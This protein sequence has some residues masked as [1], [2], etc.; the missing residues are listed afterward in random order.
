M[1][2]AQ[3]WWVNLFLLVPFAAFFLWRRNGLNLSRTTLLLVAFFGAAFGFV[4]AA[5]VV[6]L[7]AA[8]GLLPGYGGTLADVARL[9]SEIY[10]KSQIHGDL[11]GSLLTVEVCREIATMVML[12]S[13]ALLS[14]K[15]W[16]ERSAVFLWAFA[17]WD[18]GYYLGLWLT[19][20]W[21]PSLLSP[22]VLF[23][24]PVPWLAQVWF[25]ILVSA[26]TMLA[27][28]LAKNPAR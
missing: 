6:Y 3:P 24:I 4:E 5:V 16:S 8:V 18:I 21:P 19:V 22:D 1:I 25:P 9:S 10:Q 7:R 20:G 15:S 26:L 17:I 27:I 14:A 2:F 11:P 28:V 13:V 12:I 23:L